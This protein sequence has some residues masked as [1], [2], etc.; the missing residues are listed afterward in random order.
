MIERKGRLEDLWREH[1]APLVLYAMRRCP[2]REDAM[3]VVA[4]V[5]LVA[6]RRIQQVPDGPAA[7]PWLFAVARN[8][9]ANQRRGELRRS[10]LALRLASEVEVEVP[11]PSE[12]S[13][14]VA[15]LRMALLLLSERNRELI[16]LVAQDGLAPREAAEVLGISGP[17]ARVRL[18]RARAQLRKEVQRLASTGHVYCVDPIEADG[19]ETWR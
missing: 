15:A 17:A 18:H 4:E 8:L 12:P 6:W 3:D 13:E 11:E 5:Y 2:S 19:P 1:L 14:A 7:R 16:M 10:R 9:I